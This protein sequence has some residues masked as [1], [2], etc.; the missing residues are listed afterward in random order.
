MLYCLT[1]FFSLQGLKIGRFAGVPGIQSDLLYFQKI[2]NKNYVFLDEN[3]VFYII[4]DI[5]NFDEQCG[6]F[7]FVKKSPNNVNC[8]QMKRK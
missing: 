7:G 8:E 1:I 5:F 2:A 4:L 3:F 6:N